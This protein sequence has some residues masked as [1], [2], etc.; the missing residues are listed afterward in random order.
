[1]FIAPGPPTSSLSHHAPSA[2]DSR[3]PTGTG[4]NILYVAATRS[5][6]GLR[7]YNDMIPAV[8]MRNIG[9]FDLLWRD[10]LTQSAVYIEAQQRDTFRV[11]Y[12]Y[13]LVTIYWCCC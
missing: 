7:A 8:C 9:D 5:L 4:P 12:I 13:G 6:K 1:M 2:G 11:Q 3:L 10:F